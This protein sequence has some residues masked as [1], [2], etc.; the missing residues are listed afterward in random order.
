MVAAVE[1]ELTALL[2]LNE[3]YEGAFTFCPLQKFGFAFSFLFSCLPLF[4]VWLCWLIHDKKFS[5][6]QLQGL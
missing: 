2:Y 5:F 3:I 1:S 6:N 4:P